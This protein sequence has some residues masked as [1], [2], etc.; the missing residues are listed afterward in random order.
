MKKITY[1]FMLGLFA[2]GLTAEQEKTMQ[3]T[4]QQETLKTDAQNAKIR[5][6]D[7]MKAYQ[8][9]DQVKDE[10]I[11]AQ[12][13]MQTRYQKIQQMQKKLQQKKKELNE[14]KNVTTKDKQ[15]DMAKEIAS[16]EHQIQIE[17]RALEQYQQGVQQEIQMHFVKEFEKATQEIAKEKDLGAVSAGGFIYVSEEMDITQEVVDRLN[18][19]YAQTK[20]SKTTTQPTSNIKVAQNKTQ[21]TT[22]KHHPKT[23]KPVNNA[24]A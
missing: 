18:K 23:P 6:A 24:K 2:A 7:S 15:E 19:K 10:S 3:K 20:K 22:Q 13:N 4:T 8:M 1:V 12:K 16:L 21:P 14:T 5:C 9:S 11:A 17:G